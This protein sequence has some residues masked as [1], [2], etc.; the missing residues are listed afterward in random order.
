MDVQ[1][2]DG[3]V[4]RPVGAA[5]PIQAAN[6]SGLQR[7]GAED[8]GLPEAGQTKA[9]SQPLLELLKAPGYLTFDERR[10]EITTRIR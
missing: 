5:T 2:Q 3:E 1:D 10:G 8:W 6:R 4:F 9:L 7:C